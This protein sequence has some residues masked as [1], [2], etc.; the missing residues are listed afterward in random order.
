MDFSI[1]IE[2]LEQRGYSVKSFA[3]AVSAAEYL[4]AQI[5]QTTVGFGGSVTLKEM[6]LYD[7]LSTHNQV[8]NHWRIPDGMTAGEVRSYAAVA[9][10]YISSVNG[11]AETGEIVNIDGTGNRVASMIYGHKRLYLVIGRNKVL[12]TYEETLHHVR[13]VAAPKNAV[14]LGLRTPCA[15]KGDHCYNC[16]SP[17]RICNV[18]SVLWNPIK[19][20]KTE[21]ILVDEDLG[22]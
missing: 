9:D 7:L 4:T 20:C 17:Q 13:N 5:D 16:N 8:F 21:I 22:Y 1:V 2:A 6:E 19:P 12:P 14:R 11:L 10:V 3:T 18:L 15:V